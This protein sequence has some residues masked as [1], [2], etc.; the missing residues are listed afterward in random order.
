MSYPLTPSD[1]VTNVNRL[2]CIL[3]YAAAGQ[4]QIKLCIHRELFL[5]ILKGAKLHTLL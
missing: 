3:F 4:I 5:C 1:E 2:V